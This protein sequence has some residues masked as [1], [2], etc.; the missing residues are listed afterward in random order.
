[1]QLF[2]FNALIIEVI[3]L[4]E[5][6]LMTKDGVDEHN[7]VVNNIGSAQLLYFYIYYLLYSYLYC[8]LWTRNSR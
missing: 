1:M 3:S 4:V 2:Y 5:N 7:S 8:Q 6:G